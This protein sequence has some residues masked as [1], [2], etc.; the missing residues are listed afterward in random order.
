MSPQHTGSVGTDSGTLG[1]D[2]EHVAGD[3]DRGEHGA[4]GSVCPGLS[5]GRD[6]CSPSWE[7]CSEPVVRV[8]FHRVAPWL[9]GLSPSLVSAGLWSGVR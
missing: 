5:W 2:T 9:V 4:Q 3:S 8:W 1:V 7:N 6:K